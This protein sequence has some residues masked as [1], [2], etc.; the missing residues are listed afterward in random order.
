MSGR[1]QQK[2]D[3]IERR[4]VLVG[5][6]SEVLDDVLKDFIVEWLVPALVEKYICVHS[7]SLVPE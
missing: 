1:A 3:Q 5:G 2:P 4:V 6:A 7:K